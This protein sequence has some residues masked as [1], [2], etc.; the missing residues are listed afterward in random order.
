MKDELGGQ[1]MQEFAGLSGKA[2][3]HLK[4]NKK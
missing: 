1:S 2:Y 3:S 4:D